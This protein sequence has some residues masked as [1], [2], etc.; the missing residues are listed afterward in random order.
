[1]PDV[2]T[3][4]YIDMEGNTDGSFI[5]LIGVLIVQNNKE[6]KYSKKIIK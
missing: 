5:Y 4:I 6:E 2:K 3:K 1:M